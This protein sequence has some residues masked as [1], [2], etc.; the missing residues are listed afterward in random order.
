[1]TDS[2]FL[3]L[4]AKEASLAEPTACINCGKCA[5]VCPMH[6]MPMYIDFYAHAGD[7]D[8]AVKY[9]AKNCFECGTCA[10]VCP[11]KRPIVQSVRLTKMKTKEK[12]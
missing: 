8:N 5:T 3:A 7:F 4:T 11:A 12:K 2:G 6:L 9:G 10:Y 1:K